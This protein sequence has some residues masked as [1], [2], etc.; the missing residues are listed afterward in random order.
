MYLLFP[1]TKNLL[2]CRKLI[3]CSHIHTHTFLFTCLYLNSRKTFFS[4]EEI[5]EIY[6]MHKY[7]KIFKYSLLRLPQSTWDVAQQQEVNTTRRSILHFEKLIVFFEFKSLFIKKSLIVTLVLALRTFHSFI[8]T[9]DLLPFICYSSTP[10]P[11]VT[12]ECSIKMKVA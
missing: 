8:D 10:P 4:S 3:T 9:F 1:A 7:D 12:N 5:Y 11:L 6:K 2:K